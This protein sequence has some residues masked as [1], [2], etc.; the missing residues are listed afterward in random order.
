M[1]YLFFYC[2]VEQL[3]SINDSRLHFIMFCLS[4]HHLYSVLPSPF[5]NWLA[6]CKRV[7]MNIACHDFSS[8]LPLALTIRLS[9]TFF[10]YFAWLCWGTFVNNR[11]NFH[12]IL[13]NIA[14]MCKSVNDCHISFNEEICNIFPVISTRW[15]TSKCI[16]STF[17]IIR[18]QSNFSS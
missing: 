8:F 10:L 7:A 2:P 6:S 17:M 16:P 12:F 18:N 5:C 14:Y 4:S 11:A 9:S 3:T 13:C 1:A 15:F